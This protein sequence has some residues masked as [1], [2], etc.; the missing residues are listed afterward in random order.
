MISFSRAGS[1]AALILVEPAGHFRELSA[2]SDLVPL[3][4]SSFTVYT[5]DR[6]GR[7]LSGDTT[8]YAPER[9]VED[10]EALIEVAGGH[11][12][13]YGYSSGALLAL[14]AAAK[15]AAVD[16]LVLLE[17]PLQEEGQ[18]RPDPLTGQLAELIAAG[19]N[20]DAVEHFHSAIGVPQEMIEGMRDTDTWSKMTRIAHTLVYD[21]ML[22]DATTTATC[23][24]VP[25]PT[26]VLD[27]EG[28]TDDLAGWA[29]RAASLIP[30]ARHKSLPGEWHG[31]APELIAAELKG[32]FSL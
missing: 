4:T 32:F 17:P 13:L 23:R 7:G 31:V 9:E 30:M 20:G 22:S 27:S 5:Y 11:A 21:C 16:R 24:A 12:F 10:L 2:F 29:A 15:G 6:R 14:H 19:R 28:S 25:V 18:T 8:P 1:G 26:L 3:L